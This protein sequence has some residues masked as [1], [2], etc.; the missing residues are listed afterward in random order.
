[1]NVRYLEQGR[2]LFPNPSANLEGRRRITYLKHFYR[3]LFLSCAFLTL[4][5]FAAG[6]TSSVHAANEDTKVQIN[7]YLVT[8][9]DV[10][11][12]IDGSGNLQVPLRPLIDQLGYRLDWSK[13]DETV[14]VTLTGSQQTIDLQTGDNQ[15]VSNGKPVKLDSSVQYVQG[16][17][18]VP[19]R[20]IS[21]TLGY[22]IQ[23]DAANRIAIINADGA[24]HAPA[25]Y[26][27]KP[28]PSVLQTAYNYLGVPYVYGGSTPNGFDCSGYVDY[29]FKLSGISLP[30]TSVEMYDTAGTRVN[31]LQEGD[32]VFFAEG[33]RTTHVGIYLGNEQFIS[34]A[35]SS[36][37]SVASLTSGYWSKKFVGA[38]RL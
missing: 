32:L 20:F 6:H 9:P 1:V 4:G 38:K 28:K 27:S 11:P 17:V 10:K 15:A 21:E 35:S 31:D 29:I 12:F 7:D 13:K 16:N 30:R 25:W 26:A 34:A 33:R 18:F 19:L 2:N 22:R 36:G 14:K 3:K 8:F 37:V 5:L 23:W 24:Y